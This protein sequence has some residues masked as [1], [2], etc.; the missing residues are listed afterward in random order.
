MDPAYAVPDQVR[1]GV[2]CESGDCKDA[3]G[4]ENVVRVVHACGEAFCCDVQGKIGEDVGEYCRPICRCN[5]VGVDYSSFNFG[6]RYAYLG[7]VG[8]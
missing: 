8:G 7:E 1:V 5:V 2:W 4:F 3:A 6:C